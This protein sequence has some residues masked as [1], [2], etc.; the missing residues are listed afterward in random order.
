MGSDE[1]REAGLKATLSGKNSGNYGAQP[2]AAS[3]RGRY[4]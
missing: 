1:L 3:Q 4:L 2:G